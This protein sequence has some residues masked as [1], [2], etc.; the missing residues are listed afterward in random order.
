MDLAG[1]VDDAERGPDARTLLRVGISALVDHVVGV[2]GFDQSDR[3]SAAPAR[4]RIEEGVFRTNRR[5]RPAVL[6][7]GLR[8]LRRT[9]KQPGRRRVAEAD[10]FD[11][12]GA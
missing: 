3:G 5:C 11:V 8:R 7:D 1:V 2:A 4:I 9:V 6:R 12:D 10:R